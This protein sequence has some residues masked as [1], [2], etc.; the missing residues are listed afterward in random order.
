[1]NLGPV[2]PS[3]VCE[4]RRL[5]EKSAMNLECEAGP[6]PDRHGYRVTATDGERTI[7]FIIDEQIASQQLGF[8]SDGS[9]L[10]ERHLRDRFP[11]IWRACHV[12]YAE[13][14]AEPGSSYLRLPLTTG[15]FRDGHA[16]SREETPILKA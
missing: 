14:G 3:W 12:A 10:L 2:I 4:S 9:V 8:K 16:A 15:N 6:L 13:A 11:E 1:V 7:D 5:K